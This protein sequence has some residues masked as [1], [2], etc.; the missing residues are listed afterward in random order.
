PFRDG[1]PSGQPI[2]F[3]TGFLG[4]DGKTRGRP[5]GVV[6]DPKGALIVADDLSNTVWRV[7]RTQSPS[8]T[9]PALM[10]LK[11]KRRHSNKSAGASSRKLI[12]PNSSATSQHT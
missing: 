11:A 9:S 4:D 5:V 12:F 1:M 8:G 2:D 3:V 6:V 10:D 7:T